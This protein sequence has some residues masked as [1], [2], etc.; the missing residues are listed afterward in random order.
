MKTELLYRLFKES[1]GISTDSRSLK[2]DELFFA[3]SGGSFNGNR[4]VADAIRNGALAAVTDDPGCSGEK[5]IVVDDCLSELQ[6]LATFHRKILNV[7][8]LA[9]TGTNGKTTTKELLA[10]VLSRKFRIHYT[11]GNLNNH[12]GVPL[13]ILSAS[14]DTEMM[15]IEMGANHP[16]EIKLLCSVARPDFGIITNVGTAHLEGF[17]S[18][19]GVIKTKSELY[20]YLNAAG[21]TALF[22]EQNPVLAK[23]ASEI[24]EKA[25]PY[26]K[27]KGNE[28]IVTSGLII[29]PLLVLMDYL[30]K[31]YPIRTNLFG[32]H[33]L[34][35]VRAAIAM[36]LYMSVPVRDIIDAIEG[37]RPGNNRSEIRITKH[38]TLICDSYNANPTSM[39]MAI[40]S[41][42]EIG[43]TSKTM[44]LGDMFELGEKSDEEHK[45]ILDL[46]SSVK[47]TSVLLVGSCFARFGSEYGYKTF[48]STDE[49]AVFLRAEP[50]RGSFVLIKGSRGMAL[51]KIYDLL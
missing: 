9:V 20:E 19:E 1:A 43:E 34:E 4:F 47:D 32:I 15:I 22:N 48:S 27:P 17:G 45:K 8:V 36:G 14:P 10:A 39:S 51:E 26:S 5:T 3:L 41:F 13:T 28:V 29:A 49:L 38:N 23:K 7:P 21:G 31:R 46:I 37:Y 40:S 25:V 42:K 12:I 44:I 6:A 2:K 33:N 24:M 50:V 30:D 35:N 11:K 18:L 16:G